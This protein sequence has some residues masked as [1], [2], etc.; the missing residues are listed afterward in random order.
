M[1]NVIKKLQKEL[2]KEDNGDTIA[3]IL[4]SAL[5]IMAILGV[6]ATVETGIADI[7]TSVIT[8]IQNA[9]NTAFGS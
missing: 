5:V 2:M 1:K 9:L 3:K 6:S 7:A 4:V 8:F